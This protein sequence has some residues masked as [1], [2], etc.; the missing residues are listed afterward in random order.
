MR[1]RSVGLIF[2]ALACSAHPH[3]PRSAEG[4]TVL[5]VRG[6]IK[7]GPYALGRADL[8]RLPRGTVV[9]I[10]PADG[11]ETEF[12]GASLAA[13]VERLEIRRGA[14]TVIVRTADRTAT[15]LPLTMI[16]QWKPVLADRVGGARVA[17]PVVAWPNVQQRG[18]QTD[19][20]A[21]SWW[22]RDV[23]ALEVVEWQRALGTALA[24]PDGAGDDARRGAAR[25][26]ESCIACHRLRGAG[27]ERGPDLTTVAAR[28]LP[29]RFAS[30]LQ[31]HPG[32]DPRAAEES[33]SQRTDELWT[34]LRAVATSAGTR[35]E[36][37]TAAGVD[38]SE[39][40]PERDLRPP[41]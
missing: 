24:T 33:R 1:K 4:A 32:T 21:P 20:R 18:L 28:I 37:L 14:D 27:G 36:E 13:L 39:D 25:F 3:L 34:F 26:G 19:P 5:D 7:D 9:G 22:V 15:P 29:A 6:A 16:R 11:K 17:I 40:G 38:S 30:L 2:L 8:E 23:I 41:R 10:D 31:S 35:P 12:E